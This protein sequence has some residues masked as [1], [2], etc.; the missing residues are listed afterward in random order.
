MKYCTRCFYHEQHPLNIIFNEDGL[1]SGCVIHEEKNKID[2]D[3]KLIK[4]KRIIKPYKDS[5]RSINNC[6]V[7]VSGGRDSYFIVDFVKNTL[8]L[9]PL[10]VN[11][12]I[13][14]NSD[15]GIRNLS[16][17]KT[18]LGCPNLTLTVSPKRVKEITKETM[19]NIS[20]IYWHCIAGQTVFP[21]QTACRFRIPLIIWGFHQGLEQVGMF[22]H[23]NEVEMTRKY[24]KEH[25]LMGYEA[26]DILE[27]SKLRFEDISQFIYPSDSSISDVG[28][29]GIYLNNYIRWDTK[30]QQ[31]KMIN[32]Y[33]HE[34]SDLKRTFDRYSNVDCHHYSGLH[35]YIKHLK[36]GYS[37]VTDHATR[38]LRLNR[39]SRKEG[40]NLINKYSDIYP[41]D[42]DLFIK[43]LGI[44]NQEFQNFLEKSRNKNL[45]TKKNSKWVLKYP[46]DSFKIK[47]SIEKKNALKVLE[48]LKYDSGKKKKSLEK[49]ESYNL[50]GRGWE[51]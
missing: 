1:C 11:Y 21:V 50:Y 22:S 5:K 44:S 2:W 13:Q 34:T 51:N 49:K 4:L 10:L 17:L 29:R 42:M 31:E 41:N 48:N 19:K 23:E 9:N 32:K 15:I 7:P 39:L 14:Y 25:D 43:W 40:I 28:V 12:N 33:D 46:I 37:L 35:D 18:Q 3:K 20:S 24:R 47:D 30:A 38:E 36:H 26:E 6:I 8:G 16:Y 27:N 45:W